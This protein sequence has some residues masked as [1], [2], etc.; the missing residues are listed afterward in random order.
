MASP[1][2]WSYLLKHKECDNRSSKSELEHSNVFTEMLLPSHA[3]SNRTPSQRGLTYIPLGAAYAR[4]HLSAPLFSVIHTAV[5]LTVPGCSMTLTGT[6]PV[7]W[8]ECRQSSRFVNRAVR[9][10]QFVPATSQNFG[11]KS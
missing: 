9:P 1:D 11:A 4:Q 5:G 8:Q 6:I 2:V 3:N 7:A 10:H